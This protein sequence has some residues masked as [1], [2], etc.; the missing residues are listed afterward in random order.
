[1]I[2]DRQF[3]DG[4]QLVVLIEAHRNLRGGFY[5]NINFGYF[6][7]AKI[8]QAYPI[9]CF[10]CDAT[11]RNVLFINM[12]KDCLRKIILFYNFL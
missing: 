2:N 12:R 8:V 7:F 6:N 3:Y 1:M 4:L 10:R 5:G 11:M 9:K